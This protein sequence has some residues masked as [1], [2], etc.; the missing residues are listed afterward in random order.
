MP[1]ILNL[2][3]IVVLTAVLLAGMTIAALRSSTPALPQRTL[4]AL[5]ADL[6][7]ANP[8][9]AREAEREIERRWPESRRVLEA[10]AQ[11]DD[12]LRAR[13]ARRLLQQLAPPAR[14]IE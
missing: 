10:A 2:A 7:S 11:S 6:G 13:R 3:A 8:E 9:I 12:P 4:D 5:A 1:R 14:G